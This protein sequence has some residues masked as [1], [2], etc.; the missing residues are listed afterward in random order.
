MFLLEPG[1]LARLEPDQTPPYP[2]RP[3]F[4]GIVAD[5]LGEI[6]ALDARLAGAALSLADNPLADLDAVFYAT[7]GAADNEVDYQDG[8]FDG[9]PFADLIDSGDNED[10][11]RQSVQR[12][13]PGADAPIETNYEEPQP[14]I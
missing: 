14:L 7:V 6:P 11:L 9:A 2:A 3:S 8:G 5:A 13:L 1:P 4:E 10:L 12:Y